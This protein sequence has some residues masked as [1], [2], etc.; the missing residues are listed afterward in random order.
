MGNTI[1][2]IC[3][4]ERNIKTLSRSQAS[5]IHHRGSLVSNT[6]NYRTLI[7][8]DSKLPN[9]MQTQKQ[10]MLYIAFN[11]YG[12]IVYKKFI[13]GIRRDNT[14]PKNIRYITDKLE[15]GDTWHLRD[16]KHPKIMYCNGRFLGRLP[17]LR[18]QFNYDIRRK[19]YHGS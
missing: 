13:Y 7:T 16:P 6:I 14:R 8:N 1:K 15:Q 19:R 5:I 10:T 11:D 9:T 18:D 3:E 2:D 17:N 12:N 4:Y